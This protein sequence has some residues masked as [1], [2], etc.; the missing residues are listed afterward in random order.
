MQTQKPLQY[1]VLFFTENIDP[2]FEDTF[3]VQ[4]VPRA[5]T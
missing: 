3:S 4:L 1:S 5:N 2:D